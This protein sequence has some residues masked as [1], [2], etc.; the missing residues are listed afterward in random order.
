MLCAL[1]FAFALG[2]CPDETISGYAVPGLTWRLAEIDGAPFSSD[3]TLTFPEENAVVGQA[4]CNGFTARQVHPLPWVEFT[5][6]AVTRRACPDLDAEAVFFA[7][8]G[9]MTLAEVTDD[10]LIL[11]TVEGREMV[12]RAD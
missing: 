1:P 11:S 10:V 12:F 7:A 3:A 8:L 4:P 2:L 5:D 6:I 9:E